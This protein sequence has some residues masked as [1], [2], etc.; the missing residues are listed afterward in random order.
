[1]VI[2]YLKNIAIRNELRKIEKT[3]KQRLNKMNK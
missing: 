1:M 2:W 3:N